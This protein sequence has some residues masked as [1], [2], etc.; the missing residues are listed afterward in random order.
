MP[1]GP[2]GGCLVEPRYS[3][4]AQFHLE[5]TILRPLGRLASTRPA[6][7]R[8][9]SLGL[10][11][12]GV[13]LAAGC[14]GGS[15]DGGSTPGNPPEDLS[16][17]TSFLLLDLDEAIVPL[18][19]SVTGNVGSYSVEP[20]LPAGLVLDPQTG[21]ISGA[22]TAIA[23]RA[24]YILS[25]TNSNGSDQ[26]SLHVVVLGRP[27]YAL[28]V[29][30]SDS[31]ISRLA[32]ENANGEQAWHDGFHAQPASQLG[33]Q[34]IVLHPS[35][36]FAYTVNALTDNLSLHVLDPATGE[37]ATGAPI[38]AGPAPHSLA[39][40]PDG[41]F[42][43][44]ASSG[45]APVLR[46]F[47]IDGPSGALTLVDTLQNV[48]ADLVQLLADPLGR[49]LI[50]VHTSS[51]LLQSY[52]VDPGTGFPSIGTSVDLVGGGPVHAVLDQLGEQFYVASA[53]FNL[54]LRYPVTSAEGVLGTPQTRAVGEA[55]S[56]LALHPEGGFLY[57]VRSVSGDLRR[58]TVNPD[59]GV[60]TNDGDH[61]EAPFGTRLVFEERGRWAHA[62]DA[63]GQSLRILEFDP[64][65]GSLTEVRDL[66]TRPTPRAS[67]VVRGAAPLA[68]VASHMYVVQAGDES[69]R[70]YDLDSA[71][72]LSLNAVD[73]STGVAPRDIALDPRQRWAFGLDQDELRTFAIQSD[74]SLLDTNLFVV[75]GTEPIA[76][77]VDRSGRFV[78]LLDND[79]WEVTPYAIQSDGALVAV[80]GATLPTQPNPRSLGIDP[81][82][83]YLFIG[84]DGVLG[85]GQDSTLTTY[86]IDARSGVVNVSAPNSPGPGFPSRVE[87]ERAGRRAYSSLLVANTTVPYDME[88][89]TGELTAVAP[90]TP[91][92]TEPYDVL[93]T[94]DGR[95]AFVALRN[96]GNP[97]RVNAYDVRA[98]DGAL[99]NETDDNFQ[100]KQ[101]F[102]DGL[103][104]SRRLAIFPDGSLLYVL[105]EGN[106]LIRVLEIDAD[107]L[108]TGLAS[109][110]TG[111]TPR[112]MELRLVFE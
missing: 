6:H 104:L 62:I 5:T 103:L 24:E 45:V 17:S 107:G 41:T 36:M 77:T 88:S 76:I 97:G 111:A 21:V 42:L 26:T 32:L 73:V 19:P 67:V 43:Y 16:Y 20:P 54:V 75:T 99:R 18:Q 37:I 30:E 35:G 12:C 70:T 98:S 66:N 25:A 9:G 65:D 22:P 27:R 105:N 28:L 109:I 11:L 94:P 83:E 72:S 86:R 110:P 84:A 23:P 80:P 2:A 40:H 34:T 101:T 53:N 15:G 44:V 61:G 4:P 89:S 74:G 95:H 112:D 60:L 31:T 51:S 92:P 85:T 68:R 1:V 3:N 106:S 78:Y 14:G 38:A 90:G 63:L 96:P 49:F 52:P 58:F 47:S 8:A 39:L 81:T 93:L 33:P 7:P 102:T 55:P 13:L 108:L 59:T 100:P 64:L 50:S 79:D 46:T 71:G 57:A 87:F 69:I 91:S 10:L 82:G 29:N 56:W 48:P